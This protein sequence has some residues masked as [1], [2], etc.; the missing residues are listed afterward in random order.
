MVQSKSKSTGVIGFL[1]TLIDLGLKIGGVLFAVI[2]AWLI[3]GMMRGALAGTELIPQ[4][5]YIRIFTNIV[6]AGDLLTISGVT[7]IAC[8]AAKYYHDEITGYVL[9]ICGV[10]LHWGMPMAV[11]DTPRQIQPIIAYI[12]SQYGLVGTVALIVAIPFMLV[13]LWSL[14]KAEK[15]MAAKTAKCAKGATAKTSSEMAKES[16][17]YFHCWQ[18]PFCRDYMKDF[19][20]AYKKK[21]SCWRLHSGCYCDENMIIRALRG[22]GDVKSPALDRELNMFKSTVKEL[23]WLQKRARC[24]QCEMRVEHQKQKYQIASPLGFIMP[25]AAMWSYHDYTREMLK[26][27][28]MYTDKFTDMVSLGVK[29]G[30]TDSTGIAQFLGTSSMVEIIFMVCVGLLMITF[31]LRVIEYLIFKVGI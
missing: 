17:I 11:D 24:E 18:T 21:K 7:V 25:I 5:D 31:L 6:K 27:F 1:E 22:K 16:R 26:R 15:M 29:S 19:C 9:I 4:A 13:G 20:D 12:M 3:W 2:S 8:A 14:V 30:Q 23:S 10:A 28:L